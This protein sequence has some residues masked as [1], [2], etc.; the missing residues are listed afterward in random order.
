MIDYCR[1]NHIFTFWDNERIRNDL[2]I[3]A[4]ICQHIVYHYVG[5]VSRYILI[6]SMGIIVGLDTETDVSD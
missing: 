1:E 4:F 3:T 6:V 2:F 5:T